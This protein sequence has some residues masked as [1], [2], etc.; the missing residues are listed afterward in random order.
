MRSNRWGSLVAALMLATA[1]SAHE[2]DKESAAAPEDLDAEQLAVVETLNA[3]AAAMQAV[4]LDA[5]A[6]VVVA[7]DSFTYYEGTH[8]DMGWDSYRDHMAPE[9][10]LFQDTRYRFFNIRPNVFGDAA[11]ATLDFAMDVTVISDQFE[12]GKHPVSMKGIGTVVLER[13]DGAWKI[14]HLHTVTKASEAA[15]SDQSAH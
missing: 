13:Q 8:L 15:S 4:D 2:D 1:V 10:A 9:M 6:E 14:R 7:D 11:Y 5:I 12:G 3:Y